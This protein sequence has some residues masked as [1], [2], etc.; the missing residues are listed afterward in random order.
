METEHE[1]HIER[2]IVALPEL[3]AK[4]NLSN[5]RGTCQFKVIDDSLELLLEPEYS[6]E[7]RQAICDVFDM[8][9]PL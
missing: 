7:V 6:P 2:F 9:R 3:E 1:M 4:Y 5:V 8:S